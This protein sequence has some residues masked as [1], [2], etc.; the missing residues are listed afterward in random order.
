MNI[1]GYE[2]YSTYKLTSYIN[3]SHAVRW[4]NGIGKEHM[5]TWA[6]ICEIHVNHEQMVP[7]NVIENELKEV[8]QRVSGKFLNE[9]PP[10]DR[11]N[12]TLENLTTYFF[13]VINDILRKRD[14]VLTRLEIG[15]S[16]TRF[17]CITLK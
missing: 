16:P 2:T 14:A 9:V 13:S 10:F 15:E 12:P 5:H 17:Y 4:E 6:I 1:E 7:F 11:I 8:S 3:A